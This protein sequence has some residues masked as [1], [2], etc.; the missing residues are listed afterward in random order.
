MITEENMRYLEDLRTRL[1]HA[2]KMADEAD[3]K[4]NELNKAFNAKHA[5]EDRV[6]AAIGQFPKSQKN[7][8]E[9]KEANF[10]LSDHFGVQGWWRQQAV[11]LA[12]LIMAEEAYLRTRN[13]YLEE[14]RAT[15]S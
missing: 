13:K 11:Y 5:E 4:W 8:R 7:K 1:L 12:N 6:R 9:D 3:A 15:G 14:R 2:Q 10:E